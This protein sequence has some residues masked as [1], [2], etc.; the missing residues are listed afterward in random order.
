MAPYIVTQM[1]GAFAGAAVIY[2][3]FGDALRV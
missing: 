2:F 3:V 1:L